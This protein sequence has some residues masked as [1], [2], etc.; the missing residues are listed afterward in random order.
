MITTPHLRRLGWRSWTL[1][2]AA[3]FCAALFALNLFAHLFSQSLCCADDAF[4]AVAAKNLAT[5]HGYTASY[6]PLQN[7]ETSPRRF[8][9]LISTGP[10]LV[11]PAAALIRLWGNRFWVPGLVVVA[12]CLLLLGRVFW[13]LRAATQAVGPQGVGRLGLAV[14]CA[15]AALNL[16]FLRHYEHWY[17]LLGEV[18]ALLL[19]ALGVLR[20][21]SASGQQRDH[22]W[23]GFLLGCAYQTKAL[24]AL[25]FPAVFAF[26]MLQAGQSTGGQ[27][28]VLSWRR[29]LTRVVGVLVTLVGCALPT[30]I[31]ETYKWVDLGLPGYLEVKAAEA[32]YLRS[33]PGSG[34]NALLSAPLA[35]VRAI[36]PQNW[37]T[38]SS[39]FNTRWAV[40]A[41]LAA[42]V[43]GLAARD[44]WRGHEARAPLVLTASAAS[45]ATWWLLVSGQARIRYLLIGLGLWCLAVTFDVF[46]GAGS[47]RQR[48]L[49]LVAAA[50]L[51]A[52]TPDWATICPPRPFFQPSARTTAMLETAQFLA[53][54]RD[55]R[56]LAADWWATGVDMEYLLAGSGHLVHHATLEPLGAKPVLLLENSRWLGLIPSAHDHFQGAL[57]RAQAE[58][59]WERGPY[60][61]YA[62]PPLHLGI[63]RRWF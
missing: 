37:Q 11:F 44:R 13:Y 48:V 28:P 3:L 39:F 21:F 56:V 4:I 43:L 54:H 58:L 47:S 27:N 15:L 8:D 38:L 63:G 40:V 32:R 35:H 6:R 17:A 24:S 29:R 60:R 51:L 1:V 57:L 36:L 34:M 23:G 59:V 30:L 22:F 46:T 18:P 16:A 2:G 55:G 5:G 20:L 52:R 42:L 33:A 61:V 26:L 25:A 12:A 53:Q 45:F 9:P 41:F 31:F 50:A 62:V 14:I 49:A 10:V 7:G 19:L